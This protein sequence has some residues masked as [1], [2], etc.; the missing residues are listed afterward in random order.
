MGRSIKF[1]R[2]STGYV[3]DSKDM[4]LWYIYFSFDGAKLITRLFCLFAVHVRHQGGP[5]TDQGG[6]GTRSHVER[7]EYIICMNGLGR[8]YIGTNPTVNVSRSFCCCLG[9]RPCR[10]LGPSRHG[11]V[12]HCSLP[13]SVDGRR[14]S[15]YS[16]GTLSGQS[17]RRN[18]V[19]PNRPL[20]SVQAAT[21]N[22]F[23]PF[24][25]AP[26][27]NGAFRHQAR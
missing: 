2:D 13:S 17:S 10:S 27:R 20:P 3:V 23:G 22:L 8:M 1:S 5:T 25:S 24:F 9:V 6:L 14:S 16:N 7:S 11:N 26:T 19:E 15:F 4:H 21:R 12:P 18:G